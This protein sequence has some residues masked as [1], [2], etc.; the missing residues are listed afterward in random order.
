M[1]KINCCG[2]AQKVRTIKIKP[3]QKNTIYEYLFYL[4]K[5]KKC[6]QS[7]VEIIRFDLN[8]KKQKP[9]RLKTSNIKKFLENIT[10]LWEQKPVKSI[11]GFKPSLKLNYCEYGDIKLCK[12]NLSS[13]SLGIIETDPYKNLKFFQKNI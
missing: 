13:L 7:A 2:V 8:E 1:I 6:Q 11:N 3:T 4:K 12:S 9:V 5:C 10:I